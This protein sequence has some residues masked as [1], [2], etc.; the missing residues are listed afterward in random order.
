M[1]ICVQII[2]VCVYGLFRQT[3]VLKVIVTLIEYYIRINNNAYKCKKQ[4]N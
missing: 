4:K 3:F 1:Y 2:Y